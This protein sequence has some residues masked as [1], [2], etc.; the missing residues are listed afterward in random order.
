MAEMS[1]V[2]AAPDRRK[3]LRWAGSLLAGG[4][5]LWWVGSRMPLWPDRFAL[6]RPQLLVLA[7]LLHIPYAWSRAWRTA[8]VL[9]PV[10]AAQPDDSRK[11]LHRGVLLGS[12]LVSFFLVFLLPFRLGELSRPAILAKADEPGIGWAEGLA[13]AALERVIDGLLICALLFGGLALADGV[14]EVQGVDVRSMG[15]VM[16]ALFALVA[17]V[18]AVGGRYPV[19]L[20][21]MCARLLGWSNPSFAAKIERGVLRLAQAL[22]GLFV[23]RRAA[24]FVGWS[25]FYWGVTVLQLGLIAHAVGLPFNGGAAM[26]AV[27][28]IGL[29][30]QLPGGPAQIGSFQVGV[31][32]SLTVLAPGFDMVRGASFAALMY[33][34]QF[35]GAAVMTIP[36]LV[37][38]AWARRSVIA[39]SAVVRSA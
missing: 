28:M 16:L 21:A 18:L 14:D 37:L 24:G 2:D 32:A 7:G 15:L 4:L 6:D 31:L 20:S 30:I 39:R 26:A 23:L 17:A 12:G 8:F 38:L 19:Q 5:A 36:G 35:G 27:A 11:T 22:A 13:A 25:L 3:L 9:D 10:V 1:S 34:V 29:A 33:A